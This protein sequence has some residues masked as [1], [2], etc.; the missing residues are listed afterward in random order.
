M[1]RNLRSLR[2]RQ[3]EERVR[4][5]RECLRQSPPPGGWTKTIRQA[6]G[7]STSQLAKRLGIT[8]QAVLD[9][10]RR[11]KEGRVTTDALARAAHAMGCELAYAIVPMTSIAEV[12]MS[13]ART[14]AARRLS[15]VSHSMRLEAQSTTPE[16]QDQQVADL[17]ADLLASPKSL[18][19]E[20]DW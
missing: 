6:L 15:R 8:R 2:V 1:P 11:E 18:W 17:A 13:R 9:L 7:M 14:I 16:E 5:W 19:E 3:V 12:L 4:P 20:S 10:E